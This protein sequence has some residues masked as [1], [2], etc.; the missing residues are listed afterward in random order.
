MKK[1]ENKQYMIINAA[2]RKAVTLHIFTSKR[3]AKMWLAAMSLNESGGFYV[4][5]LEA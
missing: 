4:K 5:E 3:E 2:T 1:P